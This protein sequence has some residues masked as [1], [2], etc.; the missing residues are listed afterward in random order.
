[1]PNDDLDDDGLNGLGPISALLPGDAEGGDDKLLE[2]LRADFS[3][4]IGLNRQRMISVA[5][6]LVAKNGY[7]KASNVKISLLQAMCSAAGKPVPDDSSQGSVII[8]NADLAVLVI[9]LAKADGAG[10]WQ[11]R[12]LMRKMQKPGGP[13]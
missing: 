9:D 7:Q 13:S 11:C 6:A 2:G 5:A 4:A 10:W 12:N 8:G 1:M 3:D